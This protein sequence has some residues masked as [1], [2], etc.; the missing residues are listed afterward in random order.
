M[1]PE[2]EKLGKIKEKS[3][4]IGDFLQYLSDVKHLH[5]AEWVLIDQFDIF[6]KPEEP[7][8][9]LFITS[10]SMNDLLSE[11]F[12]IDQDKLEAEK[13]QMLDSMREANKNA[14]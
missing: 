8:K 2:H 6:G 10:Y 4:A 1:Y 13:R 11:F 14:S 3:Q 7:V 5:L 12:K 9:R